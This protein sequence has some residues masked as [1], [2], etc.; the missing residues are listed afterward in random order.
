MGLPFDYPIR[1]LSRRRVRSLLIGF[2]CALVA[3]V[4][5]AAF[6]FVGGLDR[7]LQRSGR[8]DVAILLSS[9][10]QRD[11]VRSAL[12][13]SV[14]ELVTAEIDGILRIDDVPA[15]S[16]EIHMATRVRLAG[17]D[18]ELQGFVRGVTDRA[19]LVHPEVTIT[20]GHWPGVGEVAVGRLVAARLGVDTADVAPGKQI[21]ME[22]AT[23]TIA[24]VFS[25]PGTTTEA[26]IWAPLYELQGEARRPDV[27]AVFVRFAD[28]GEI[29]TLE[30][31]AGRRLDLEMTVIRA[32]EYYAEL[33]AWFAP[34]RGLVWIMV[35]LI[36]LT[37][38]F[39][40]ANALQ[41]SVEERTS[42]LATLRALG[43][44]P[45]SILAS[46]IL[47]SLILAAAGAL[48]GLLL[49]QLFVR[50]SAFRIGMGAFRLEVDT[51]AI[52]ASFAIVLSLALLGTLPAA[53][54]ILRMRTAFALKE[55]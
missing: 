42:E 6:A 29:D 17:R 22:G 24:G 1:N 4:L 45:R 30:A 40:G 12:A 3:A 33:S 41:M 15:V 52:A 50:G 39:S 8:S 7:S 9:A 35:L 23:W 14:A 49:A 19:L 44:G 34:I 37:V 11:L 43:F 2:A 28:P 21:E 13:P 26:E 54:R 18:R 55:E 53:I 36:A 5:V 38:V 20:N 31:Y 25:A 51:T 10:A 47:E 48:T 16:S 27:S 32:R 46:L